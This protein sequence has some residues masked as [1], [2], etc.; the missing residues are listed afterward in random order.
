MDRVE[1]ALLDY[2][3]E[4][5]KDVLDGITETARLAKKVYDDA[6]SG[7]S[8]SQL[9]TGI[10]E[11]WSASLHYAAAFA[12]NF[13]ILVAALGMEIRSGA[14]DSDTPTRII[15]LD[16]TNPTAPKCISFW[17]VGDGAFANT[18]LNPNLV[19]FIKTPNQTGTG[20]W[21]LRFDLKAHPVRGMYAVV[22]EIPG[23]P[24]L[25]PYME[26]FYF[27]PQPPGS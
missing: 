27:D 3:A 24:S 22:Y 20:S 11:Y 10:A 23:T 15:A 6:A 9:M 25:I 18:Q 19:T 21:T 1:Q 5:R 12:T 16:P 26:H 14:T 13:G 2:A 17:M 8:E 4:Q 7:A